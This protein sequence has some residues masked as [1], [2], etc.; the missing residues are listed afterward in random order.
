MAGVPDWIPPMQAAGVK[1]KI[2]PTDEYFPHMAQGIAVSDQLIKEKPEM[3]R[4][5]VKAAM[6]GMKD[7]MDDPDK[8]AEDFVKFVPEWKGKEDGGQ[9]RVQLLRQAGLCRTEAT[10]RDQR[11]AA[12]QAAGLL[13]G[14]GLHPEEDAGRG[15]LHQP[16]HQVA[17]RRPIRQL[18]GHSRQP[19]APLIADRRTGTSRYFAAVPCAPRRAPCGRRFRPSR[20][21]KCRR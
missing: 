8:A 18:V 19:V 7:M 2:I 1:V 9:D 4:K 15:A 10:R 16:V 6:R 20:D 14:E 13:S 3:I 5:F 11:G 17:Q 21:G 12:E